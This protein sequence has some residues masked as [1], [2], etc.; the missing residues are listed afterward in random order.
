MKFGI[1]KASLCLA[2]A[3]LTIG[4]CN[5][6]AFAQGGLSSSLPAAGFGVTVSEGIS[7][8][9]AKEEVKTLVK[10]EK[11]DGPAETSLISQ[12]AAVVEATMTIDK[13]II[14]TQIPTEEERRGLGSSDTMGDALKEYYK[15]LV[16]AQVDSYVNVRDLP[17]E[18]DGK[19]V[20]KLYNN[21]V[22]DFIEEVDGWY[23]IKSGNCTG[24]VKGEYC[25]T[26]EDAVEVAKKVG[27]LIA[28]VETTT[29]YVREDATTESRRLGMVG[30]GDELVVTEELEGWVKVDIEEGFGYV[31][32]E[33]V[34]LTTEFVKAESKEEEE[35][36]LK[37]EKEEREKANA[38]ARRASQA[39]AAQTASASGE[40]AP[41]AP[42]ASISGSGA[43]VDV[44]NYAL[45]FVGNPY[46][47]GGSSLTNGTD[48]SGFVMSVYANFG[49]SLPHSSAGDRN[50]GYDVGGVANAQPGD[51]VCYSGHVGIYIGNGQIVHASTSRTGIV[52][53]SVNYRTPLC[54][55]RIF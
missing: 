7:V 5:A 54:V 20:G 48:C 31:S 6:P 34:T 37:K 10:V 21:S 19:I 23:K 43:G 55:R 40:A 17:S 44:V 2:V 49:V 18:V 8:K 50:V 51:I 12:N 22:G 27:K 33:Y 46:V 9:E 45:Q 38:A 36:R 53:G 15:N 47:F 52:V 1:V 3:G 39:A 14:D 28:T 11:L 35:A 29:L 4:L 32:K 13:E 16:I 42:A 26:G 24:Y 30:L 25:V 41:A